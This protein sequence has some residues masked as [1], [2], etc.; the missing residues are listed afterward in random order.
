LN[1]FYLAELE[2][3]REGKKPSRELIIDRAI[4]IRKWIDKHRAKTT[5]KILA[6]GKVYQY[7]NRVIVV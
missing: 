6:G 2:L 1:L 5:E 4:K 7:E 3:E